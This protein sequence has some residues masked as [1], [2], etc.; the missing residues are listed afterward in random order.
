MRLSS[1]TDFQHHVYGALRQQG[2]LRGLKP[3]TD[4][5][6]TVWAK[7][8]S[9]SNCSIALGPGW[10]LR[11]HFPEGTFEWQPVILP[12]RTPAQWEGDYALVFVVEGPT[13]GLWLDSV[14]V[15]EVVPG[16]GQSPQAI[17]FYDVADWNG[18]SAGLRFYPALRRGAPL[19][20]QPVVQVRSG[21]ES[22][23][24][25]ADVR[26]V[27]DETNLYFDLDVID[28]SAGK[29]LL[30]DSMWR[31]DSV[32]VHIQVDDVTPAEIG[33]ALQENGQI[34]VFTWDTSIDI[35]RIQR[36]G[37][38]TPTGYR[39]AIALPWR[40]FGVMPGT[41]PGRVRANI[42]VN[43]SGT[44]G[45][46]RFVEWTPATAVKKNPEALADIELS[47]ASEGLA[48][49]IQLPVPSHDRD[50]QIASRVVIHAIKS[51][52]IP[53]LKLVLS[54][55]EKSADGAPRKRVWM[56]DTLPVFESITK[57]ATK[58]L[59]FSIDQRDRFPEGRYTLAI[60]ADGSIAASTEVLRI[61]VANRIVAG[62]ADLKTHL[63]RLK[64]KIATSALRYDSYVIQGATTAEVFLGRLEKAHAGKSL[65]QDWMLLQIRELGQVLDATETRVDRGREPLIVSRG[66][67]DA[68]KN[69]AAYTTFRYGFGH[70]EAPF[71]DMESLSRMGVSLVQ[72][73][74]GGMDQARPGRVDG[75]RRR[76]DE[77]FA[78]AKSNAVKVDLLLSPHY[79]PGDLVQQDPSLGLDH[80]VGS[81]FI[82]FNIDHPVARKTVEEWVNAVVPMVKDSPA[83]FSIGLSNE[84]TYAHS[85][86]DAY[87]REKWTR[88]LQDRHGS[89]DTL[90][91]LYG[92]SYA[93][94]SDVPVPSTTMPD[95]IAKMRAFYDW[96]IF[97]K[98]NFADW[99]RWLNDIVK[100]NAPDV[101]THA[102]V[103]P[104]I[105]ERARFHEGMDPELICEITDLAGNDCWAYPQSASGNAYSWKL[106]DMW[107]D[108]LHS[109][110]G[111][112]VFNSENHLI[113]DGALANSIPPEHTYSVLWQGALHHQGATTIWVWNEPV[114]ASLE[115]SIYLR[116]G[117]TWSAGKAMLD[118]N[119]LGPEVRAVATQK[120][121][122]AILYSVTSAFW[123]PDYEPALM[124]L[125][126]TLSLLGHQVTFISERQ[127]AAG[128]RSPA[129]DSIRLIALPRATHV[130][131][132]TVR[133]LAGFVSKGGK[134]FSVGD[135][136]LLRDEYGRERKLPASLS[137]NLSKAPW[138]R[139]E[140]SDEDLA[141]PVESILGKAGVS[142]PLVLSS[143]TTGRRVWGIQHRVVKE[144]DTLLISLNNMTKTPETVVLPVTGVITDILNEESIKPKAVI[145]E[146]MKPRLL[147]VTA[148]G[149]AK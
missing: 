57:G 75:L 71:R 130:K 96:C 140:T 117:N 74:L 1:N 100:R 4:Y 50:Q 89:V 129:N 113:K 94:F 84:P 97:N 135:G 110:R 61:D 31:G 143:A 21:N 90:N 65:S 127:L 11:K 55:E 9:V 30:G 122:V 86:R 76:V 103:M 43:D 114:N 81:G 19:A 111:Q 141:T 87:S 77:A 68:R 139:G 112:P 14:T 92:T 123:E 88:Y 20:E 23:A 142:S 73:E 82:K 27:W 132:E 25:G 118:L 69:A 128:R 145:L 106:M 66:G 7:G 53:S 26:A 22:N 52:A 72:R 38:R 10:R 146:P 44:D 56:T 34:G 125:Y 47:V 45:V 42:V 131:E 37:Q 109:F 3:D 105:F 138:S 60:E 85:G 136:S 35:A 41:L 134:V 83:L 133:A 70:W 126:T 59:S 124:S 115:G 107:Y 91:S 8:H 99:H 48:Y 2:G 17:E 121:P 24:F 101:P 63:A 64:G 51:G 95:T 33:F 40:E 28:P 15:D 6:L 58:S 80:S 116:P 137:D 120:A 98:Q 46:R 62:I 149:T 147:R 93:K 5:K 32:Q 49:G 39:L 144:G 12:F 102:K 13:E 148:V 108:L 54:S 36:S 78:R 67:D 104:F 18:I 29:I 119:R 79:F 16:G